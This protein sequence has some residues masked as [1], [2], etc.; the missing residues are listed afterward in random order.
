MTLLA[1]TK[2]Q[3]NLSCKDDINFFEGR[4]KVFSSMH[5]HVTTM[6][7]NMTKF[8]S[9]CWFFFTS[10][11][12][13]GRG[14]FFEQCDLLNF[15]KHYL[16]QILGQQ[17]S[18]I[19]KCEG[20]KLCEPTFFCKNRLKLTLVSSEQNFCTDLRTWPHYFKSRLCL[21]SPLVPFPFEQ[22]H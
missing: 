14:Y 20:K 17:N 5:R 21:N 8:W 15:A 2:E 11:T 3:C 4:Q 1:S 12:K 19:K 10:P 7:Q 22:N 9:F 6:S 16:Q 13:S 18:L